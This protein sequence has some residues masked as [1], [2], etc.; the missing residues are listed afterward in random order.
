MDL[1]DDTPVAAPKATEDPLAELNAQLGIADNYLKQ[2]LVEEAIEIFQQLL[3]AHPDNNEIRVKLNQ[4][5]TAYV[6]TGDEVIGALEAEKKAKEDEERRIREEM[7]RKAEEETKRLRE[8]LE[9]KARA[10]AERQAAQ[11][12]MERKAREESEKKISEEL[13]QKAQEETLQKAKQ[14]SEQKFREETEKK[15]REEIERKVREEMIGKMQAQSPQV[16]ES[17]MA[18]E[19]PAPVKFP[20]PPPPAKLVMAAEAVPAKPAMATETAPAKPAMAPPLSKLDTH[21]KTDSALEESRD[22]F[23]TV[24]VAEIYTRQGLY[25]EA[26]KIYQRIIHAEPDNF[27]AKKKLA[28]VENLFKSKGGKVASSAPAPASP[29]MEAVKSVPGA[30]PAPEKPLD[31]EKDSGG[32]K[33]SNRVG[34]V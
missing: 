11:A 17:P 33:K 8:E 16:T 4:A 15:I 14:G 7:E 12:D 21:S 29:S 10:E 18:A 2:N 19:P 31:G 34:Y 24:A 6:K 22:E 13:Q 32:K 20:T 27:E 5:Y 23:M 9:Q 1:E 3:E 26:I 25:E 30:S 28:D